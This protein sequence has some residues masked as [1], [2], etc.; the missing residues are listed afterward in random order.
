MFASATGFGV[1]LNTLSELNGNRLLFDH[2]A[3][4]EVCVSHIAT[5]QSLGI[6]SRNSALYKDT[7]IIAT[8]KG[9]TFALC[10]FIHKVC[11]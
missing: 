8:N 1:S 10:E 11:Q 3:G 5:V 4:D 2:S 6:M 9:Q 7:D